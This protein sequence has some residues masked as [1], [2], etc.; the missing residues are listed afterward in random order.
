M[1]TY[2]DERDLACEAALNA[3]DTQFYRDTEQLEERLLDYAREH[4]L[5]E[6]E[7]D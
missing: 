2:A 1:P 3:L 6:M 7:T 4:R 5:Y